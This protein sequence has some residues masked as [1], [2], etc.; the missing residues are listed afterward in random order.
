MNL[1][2]EIDLCCFK[3][4]KQV[5]TILCMFIMLCFVVTGYA[6]SVSVKGIVKD[7]EG[8]PLPGAT[9]VVEG[10]SRGV[11]T[12]VDGSFTI[13]VNPSD[14]IVV[15]YLGMEKQIL[16]VGSKRSFNI[17]METQANELEEVSIV[18]F[19]KQKKE[20]VISSISTV[21]TKELKVPSSNLTTA[22][23][24]RIAGMISYQRSGE[25]GQNTA[26]FFIRG[27]TTFGTGKADPLILI[28]NIELSSTDLARLNPDDIESFSILKD[29]TATALYGARGANGVIMVTTKE[30]KEG[31]VKVSARV[32]SSLSSATKNI[33]I[34]D[35]VTFMRMHNE[36]VST[37]D[38]LATVPYSDRDIAMREQGMNPYVYPAV[39]WYDL[40]FKDYAFT[41]R[42]NLSVSG[43]GKVARYYVAL[44]YAQE[45]GNLAENNMNN[46]N[47][48][49]KLNQYVFRSNININLSKTTQLGLR[50]NAS[51]DDYNGP[52]DGGKTLYNKAINA[53]PVLFPAYYAPD[54]ANEFTKHVLFGN[55]SLKGG[56]GDYMNPYA[57]MIRGYKEYENTVF[58]AQLELEQDLSFITKGL[59]A[60]VLFN[61][62]RNSYFDMKRSFNPFYYDVIQYD[63]GTDTYTLQALNP[64]QGTDY[65][66]YNV[67]DGTRKVSSSMYLEAALSYKNKFDDI[68][69]VS[70]MLVFT[71]RESKDG[72]AGTLFESLASRNLGLAGRFTYG[73]D[74]R[75]YIEANFGYN[76]S[77]RFSKHNRWGFFPSAGL[78]WLVSNESFWS[79]NPISKVIPKFKLKATY[80]LVGNDAIASDRFFY[81]SDVNMNNSG[82][83]YTFGNTFGNK[84]NG[85]SINRYA[86]PNITWEISK[87]LNV[88]FEMNL[89]DKLEIQLDYF[90]ETRSNILQRRADIPTI[91][92][93]QSIPSSNIGEA[94]GKGMEL[95]L[96]YSHV[97]NRDFWA[98]FRGNFTYATSRY[99]IYEEPDYSQT[100]A[101]WLSKE[102]QK[103]SQQYGLIA[104]RLFIDDE[105]V[106]NSPVQQFGEYGA[107][108]IKYT[109]VNN[110]GVVNS[111]D[112]VPIGKP[113]TPEIIY[114][115]GS[116][117]G[118][119]SFDFSFFFQGSALSSFW[120]NPRAISPFVNPFSSGAI[121]NNA[122]LQPIADSYWSESNQDPY[123]F[124]PRL[125]DKVIENNVQTS[126]WFMRNGSFL[127]LK[128][129][130][131]GYTLPRKL[132][133]KAHI[134]NLRIYVS[135]SNLFC[136]SGFDMWDIEMGGDGLGYPI[137]RVYN[138]GLQLNF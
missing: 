103:I 99:S 59:E 7:A 67:N 10:T 88:G 39:D 5:R 76:G 96:D 52:I 29:A 8:Y 16:P 113:K 58:S 123:A 80:G 100:S 34:A 127:R 42:G 49:I 82:K 51:F 32:E 110:D 128:S 111:E 68:H 66:S 60:R 125:S 134:E 37:R 115:F 84:K 9:I 18:A 23:A 83:G 91:I 54:A 50:M 27:V 90:R 12:D 81:L 106:K 38:P 77:E 15:D 43:G 137:Q 26:D 120:I 35:P 131:I 44:S 20:S 57:D 135:G 4:K 129:A 41:T 21:S 136:I 114:G 116:S 78:G 65:L 122:V 124:W 119:K 24:G 46:F 87:K 107:G 94:K 73:Y 56:T 93:L 62:T 13:E 70:G 64:E 97:F 6:Q 74:S 45:N 30:G 89:Y 72:N 22:F 69:D 61:T 2:K 40:M 53:N 86:D 47:S 121:G 117:L 108:D 104:E 36:A 101:P 11:I 25:P 75:Y 55:S 19:G 79:D 109:D 1:L 138:I 105:D 3:V 17:I 14:K 102:G 130:E 92:G 118:Y 71:A 33:D 132:L 98:T 63:K 48:N 133:R 28:D 126:T 85:I 95:S 112:F 31:K